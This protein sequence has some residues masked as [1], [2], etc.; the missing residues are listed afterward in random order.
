MNSVCVSVTVALLLVVL[1]LQTGA[2][3]NATATAS[4]CG[5]R[6]SCGK[7]ASGDGVCVWCSGTQKCEDTTIALPSDVGIFLFFHTCLVEREREPRSSRGCG[8]KEFLRSSLALIRSR[9]LP[10]FSTH[11]N[12]LSTLFPP[13]IT[14]VGCP[15][16]LQ[17]PARAR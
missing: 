3:S 17:K 6:K 5:E 13:L 14:S 10:R 15:R 7:C 4:P 8:R 9:T 12:K 2:D 1:V 16:S 11:V